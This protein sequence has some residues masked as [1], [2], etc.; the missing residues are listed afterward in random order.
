VPNTST[1]HI[2]S[3]DLAEIVRTWSFLTFGLES[4]VGAA[5]GALLF[6]VLLILAVYDKRTRLPLAALVLM[7]LVVAAIVSQFKPMWL[8]RVFL[9]IVPFICLTL[10]IGATRPDQQ[11]G[12]WASFRTAAFVLLAV[13]WASIGVSQ[14]FTR[15]K[16]DG[17]KPAAEL[18]HS[19]AQP[20]DMILVDGDFLYWCFNWYFLGPDWGE[21]RHAFVLNADWA[22]MMKRLPESMPSWL[23]LNESASSLP[24]GDT[25]VKL[26]DRN[27]PTPESTAGLIVVRQQGSAQPV[28][29]GRHLASAAHLQQ[30]FVER[31]TR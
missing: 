8:P 24:S 14:Q 20:G 26:W 4:A 2:A 28:F 23:D 7:P 15:Q 9:P 1:C 13:A 29:A 12:T 19:I 31:W 3:P 5:L 6:A 21:P 18:V 11:S 30:L 17:F 22:R 16:G 10:G 27:K 25:I